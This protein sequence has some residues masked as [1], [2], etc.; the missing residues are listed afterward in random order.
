MT[1]FWDHQK[2]EYLVD[3]RKHQKIK[4]PNKYQ[5][6]VNLKRIVTIQEDKMPRFVWKIGIIEEFI[7]RKDDN[8][9]GALESREQN[10]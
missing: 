9:Q 3:L 7:K 4:H 1:H 5:Q 8:I 10:L 2:K 6:I